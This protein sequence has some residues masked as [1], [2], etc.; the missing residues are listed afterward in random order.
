MLSAGE[1]NM[2]RLR[3]TLALSDLLQKVC[4]PVEDLGH[5]FTWNHNLGG[6]NILYDLAI[7]G[8][9]LPLPDD[10]CQHFS[11]GLVRQKAMSPLALQCF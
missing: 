11:H 8:Q 6:T 4:L 5:P 10:N 1:I 7:V 9:I 3:G 2:Y